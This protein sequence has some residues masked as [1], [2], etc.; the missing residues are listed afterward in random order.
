MHTSEAAICLPVLV[1]WHLVLATDR[2]DK[3]LRTV[4][5]CEA[6]DAHILHSRSLGSEIAAARDLN[7]TGKPNE[8]HV[9]CNLTSADTRCRSLFSKCAI[10]HNPEHVRCSVS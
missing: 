9:N 4:R 7:E 1:A 5:E 2:G 3:G 6:R 10:R 8:V